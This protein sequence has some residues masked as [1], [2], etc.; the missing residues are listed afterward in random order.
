MED[1]SARIQSVKAQIQALE[2]EL[3]RLQQQQAQYETEQRRK[4]QTAAV[5][6]PVPPQPWEMPASQ[7][8]SP[9]QTKPTKKDWDTKFGRNVL[10]ILASA[11][12]FIGVMLMT[13]AASSR[14]GQ[15]LGVFASGGFLTAVGIFGARWKKNFRTSFLTVAGCGVGILYLGI[16]LTYWYYQWIPPLALYG[17]FLL[18][19]VIVFLISR[20]QSAVFRVIGQVGMVVAVFSSIGYSSHTPGNGDL[21]Q[22]AAQILCLFPYFLLSALFYLFT[23]RSD[24]KPNR[25]ATFLLNHFCVF[26]LEIQLLLLQISPD[27]DQILFAGLSVRTLIW[28]GAGLLLLFLPFQYFWETYQWR[29]WQKGTDSIW[30]LHYLTTF[31]L[32]IPLWL[33]LAAAL[34]VNT[35]TQWTLF[36]G[37]IAGILA[38]WTAAQRTHTVQGIYQLH[39]MLTIFAVLLLILNAPQ[40]QITNVLRLFTWL[41]LLAFLTILGWRKHASFYL[42]ISYALFQLFTWLF[43]VFAV[44][45]AWRI[46]ACFY[47]FVGFS[48]CN[49]GMLFACCH[50]QK[51]Q[52]LSKLTRVIHGI[53]M[54]TCW[55]F[56]LNL[57]MTWYQRALIALVVLIMY[58]VNSEELLQA[59]SARMAKELWCCAKHAAMIWFVVHILQLPLLVV[60]FVWEALILG[61]MFFG[62]RK[63]RKGIRISGLLLLLSTLCIEMATPLTERTISRLICAVIALMTLLFYHLWSKKPSEKSIAFLK[64]YGAIPVAVLF[65]DC[66][67]LINRSDSPD[68]LREL[69]PLCISLIMFAT[70]WIGITWKKFQHFFFQLSGIGAVTLL[71]ALWN[72]FESCSLQVFPWSYFPCLLWVG[73]VCILARKRESLFRPIGV[74]GVCCTVLRN[75]IWLRSHFAA[76]SSDAAIQN[77]NL[78]LFVGYAVL[79]FALLTGTSRR[80]AKRYPLLEMICHAGVVFALL[81]QIDAQVS[82]DIRQTPIVCIALGLLLLSI[83]FQYFWRMYKLRYLQVASDVRWTSLFLPTFAQLLVLLGFWAWHAGTSLAVFGGSAILLVAVWHITQHRRMPTQCYCVNF[84]GIIAAVS[85]FLLAMPEHFWA[86]KNLLWFAFLG[87]LFLTS[88]S[89]HQRK[90]TQI[91]Y[92]LF[93]FCSWIPLCAIPPLC[94]MPANQSFCWLYVI[95][96]AVLCVAMLHFRCVRKNDPFFWLHMSYRMVLLLV[97]TVLLLGNGAETSLEVSLPEKIV[98]ACAVTAVLLSYSYSLLKNPTKRKVLSASGREFLF[99]LQHALLLPLL[100]YAFHVPSILL[101]CGFLCLA[102]GYI[103]LGF[104]RPYRVIRVF[105]LVLVMI[106]I[107]KL[108]LLD[109]SYDQL[110]LRAVSFLFC[111]ALCLGISFF[112]HY[113]MQKYK[114]KELEVVG[115]QKGSVKK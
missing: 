57:E 28:F 66:F 71:Y 51:G 110:F 70:G 4:Q 78:L 6:S 96:A 80:D 68:V 106:S 59:T 61:R 75:I 7:P 53:G 1:Q 86:A 103:I 58:T 29:K 69:L 50:M 31:L 21:S 8:L 101:S 30:S 99:G 85:G 105:G 43:V 83:L 88:K 64:K 62:I 22:Y 115:N 3:F 56:Q 36:F 49:C 23:A 65:C 52:T 54:V 2:M 113:M 104:C 19:A 77:W 48:L 93:L 72:L 25:I 92:G 37:S 81:F 44:P 40:M 14:I 109:I 84:C 108:I 11:L 97:G 63:N 91:V 20:K 34:P 35:A 16:L 67:W 45:S 17:L 87:Y 24:A 55:A 102:I 46:S 100:L 95:F 33:L 13:Y 112:Y 15:M 32:W 41:F 74:L 10:G 111:G 38:F 73:C 89:I 47:C 42:Q 5:T 94:S 107:C 114:K 12:I 90:F 82:G 60:L 9:P 76:F 79:A 26:L 98:L 39:L 27:A 18:W